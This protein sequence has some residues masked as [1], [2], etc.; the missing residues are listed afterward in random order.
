MAL[1]IVTD[2]KEPPEPGRHYLVPAVFYV[3]GRISR[4]PGWYP[5]I[6]PKHD[7]AEH[8]NF[9]WPHYHLDRRFMSNRQMKR[10]AGD[11]RSGSDVVAIGPIMEP[12][13]GLND[14]GSMPTPT[15]RQMKCHR[16]EIGFPATPRGHGVFS[17]FHE[18]FLGKKCPRDAEGHLI[19]PHKGARLSSLVPN[20]HGV[21][22]CP[23][24]GLLIDLATETVVGG[25]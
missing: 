1:P 15:L 24:H 17:R 16:S 7:D 22:T 3:Y 14:W 8:L 20:E 23:L 25:T 12:I 19:C 2:L 9:K 11:W 18:T 10:A 4:R 13:S 6:G 21:I 5:V